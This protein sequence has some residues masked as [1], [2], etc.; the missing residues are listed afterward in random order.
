MVSQ[1]INILEIKESSD[2]E[3]SDLPEIQDFIE[4]MNLEVSS[5]SNYLMVQHESNHYSTT[6]LILEI[7]IA[8][9]ISSD[10]FDSK[11]LLHKVLLDTGCT[12]TIIKKQSHPEK[13]FKHGSETP[14]FHGQ[15][16]QEILSQNM[17]FLYVLHYQN[18]RQ[19]AKFN[20]M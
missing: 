8:I 6:G 13:K 10:A 2:E 11:H 14:S 1:E 17:I 19:V 9:K 20:G 18:L 15:L 5:F 7:S 16:I 4:N 12:K 3:F